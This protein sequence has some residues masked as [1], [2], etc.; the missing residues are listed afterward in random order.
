MTA[1]DILNED[2]S[3]YASRLE[4]MSV[5]EV[6]LDMSVL[7]KHSEA[8]TSDRDETLSRIM[9]VEEEIE[10]RYPGQMLAPYRD[11][12]KEQPFRS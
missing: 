5:D 9:L 10:K 2:V 6:F 8:E 7:E 11:W 4:A 1:S 12:K 3:D